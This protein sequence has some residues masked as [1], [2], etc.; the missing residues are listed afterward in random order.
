VGRPAWRPCRIIPGHA[1]E[2]A[3]DD[4]PA[5]RALSLSPFLLVKTSPIGSEL[6]DIGGDSNAPVEV[7]KKNLGAGT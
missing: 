3:I 5:A 4:R 7:N 1:E 6:N 2:S